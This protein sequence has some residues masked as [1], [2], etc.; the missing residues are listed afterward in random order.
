[1]LWV[2]T[3]AGKHGKRPVLP[4]GYDAI[5]TLKLIETGQNKSSIYPL[6]KL[7]QVIR[8]FRII[9]YSQH[10]ILLTELFVELNF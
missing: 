7:T 9:K 10:R 2:F 8:N 6:A 1:M 3:L 4:D 5:W